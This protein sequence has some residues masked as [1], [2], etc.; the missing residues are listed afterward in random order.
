[1][2]N[3]VMSSCCCILPNNVTKTP[4]LFTK[5]TR[6]KD[7]TTKSSGNS[8]SNYI[9]ISNLHQSDSNYYDLKYVKSKPFSMR[10][11]FIMI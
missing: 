5:T 9:G 7:K 10:N 4:Y 2:G 11:I 1:M 3:K 6:K 8:D